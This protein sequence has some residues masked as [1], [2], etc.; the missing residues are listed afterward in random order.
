DY[1]EDTKST[2]LTIESESAMTESVIAD[3]F[4]FDIELK[5][6]FFNH[7]SF[8]KAS[9]SLALDVESESNNKNEYYI[10]SINNT[11]MNISQQLSVCSI[12]DIIDNKIK[13]YGSHSQKQR[14]LMQLIKA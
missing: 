4:D 10:A 5:Y 12:L 3:K 7:A 2:S 11:N 9:S 1:E 13:C 14:P 6:L 8:N